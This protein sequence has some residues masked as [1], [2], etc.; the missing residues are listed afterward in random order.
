MEPS[1]TRHP[2]PNTKSIAHHDGS[3]I[4]CLPR[5]LW[6]M[7][8]LFAATL[9]IMRNASTSTICRST[10]EWT[11]CMGTYGQIAPASPGS[12]ALSHVVVGPGLHHVIQLAEQPT[13]RVQG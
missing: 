4:Y 9:M 13:L 11:R 10:A 1:G 2:E 8:L 7:Y 12:S 5:G 3:Q 6:H